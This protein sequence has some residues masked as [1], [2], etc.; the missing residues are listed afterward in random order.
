MTIATEGPSS[1]RA[2]GPLPTRVGGPL[3]A[4]ASYPLVLP[5]TG[6]NLGAEVLVV[7]RRASTPRHETASARSSRHRMCPAAAGGGPPVQNA[8]VLH[9]ARWA[10]HGCPDPAFHTRACLKG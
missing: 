1:L 3:I 6:Q 2:R 8:L 10:G 7:H 5:R 4:V 9:E